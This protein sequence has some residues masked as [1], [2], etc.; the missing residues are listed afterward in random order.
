[1]RYRTALLS[2]LLAWNPQPAWQAQ[3]PRLQIQCGI[4][5]SRK[6]DFGTVK[7]TGNT[8]LVGQITGWCRNAQTPYVRICVGMGRTESGTID[9]RYMADGQ[10]RMAFNIYANAAHTL[11]WGDGST[12]LARIIPIDIVTHSGDGETSRTWYGRV[13][14]QPELPEGKYR[15]NFDRSNT[16]FVVHGYTSFPPFCSATDAHEG[17]F[18]FRVEATVEGYCT[19]ET[20]PLDFGLVGSLSLRVEAESSISVECT[21]GTAYELALDAGRGNGA[22]M[23]ER[24]VTRVGGNQTLVYR[25]FNDEARLRPWGDGSL[26]TSTVSDRGNGRTQTHQVYGQLAALTGALRGLYQDTVTAT[27]TY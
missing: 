18:S 22:T 10:E 8:D 2:L 25:L 20:A 14:P 7:P 5:T 15:T 13:P 16:F 11:I 26:G 21:D 19:L 9:P 4:N 27:L 12:P 1:M 23:L 17:T 24:K 6:V 3:A